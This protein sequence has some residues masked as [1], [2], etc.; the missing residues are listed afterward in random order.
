VAAGCPFGPA[1][2]V[3]PAVL[4]FG[5]KSERG[6][7][8][9]FNEGV[10]ALQ[11]TAAEVVWRG[12]AL[13]WVEE[14][15]PWLSIDSADLSGTTTV[16][17]ARVF[18]N[19]TRQGLDPG[20][21]AGAGIR[22]TSNG[23][24]MTVPVTM[25]VP[26]STGPGPDQGQL[27]VAPTAV[28]IHGLS[29][30]TTFM[31]TNTGGAIVQWYTAIRINAPDAQPD[32]PIQIAATPANAATAPVTTT[33][34]TVHVPNPAT[35]NS[36]FLT[37]V[38]AVKN[39][40]DDTVAAEVN[41]TVDLVGP[42]AI[43]A[44]PA[45]LD[46]GKDGY[47]VSFFVANVGDRYSLLNF[48]AFALVDDAY[49]PYDVEADPLIASI[50]AP[51]GTLGVK[52]EVET[53]WVNAREVSVTLSRDGI[54][55]DLEFRELYIGAVK[56]TDPSGKPMIDP[57]IAP[58]QVEVRVEAAPFVEGATN[59]SR[60]PSIMRFI[61]LLRDKRGLAVDAGDARIR[62]QMQFHVQEDG[63]PLD[64]DESS[65]F[66]TGP[67][68]LKCNVA[69]LLD[70][71]G[72]MYN[73]GVNDRLNP[74]E[75]GDAIVQMVESAKQFILDLPDS[76]RIA[77]ME[78]HDR[79]QPSR[80]IHGFDTDKAA[81]TGALDAFSLPV[82]EHGASDI[83]DALHDACQALVNEDPA[84]TLPF[85]EADV[86]SVVFVSDG[87][88][89]SSNKRI[90]EIIQFAK[91]SRVRLYPLGF[92]GR[93]STPVNGTVLIQLATE[94]GG[95]SYYAPELGDLT[96]LLDTEKE[97]TFNKPS[98]DL[99][100]RTAT[101]PLRNNGS[102]S[103]TWRALG[104]LNWLTV[105]PPSGT[106]PP[107]HRNTDGVID[108]PGV[109]A[110]TLTVSSGLT[111]GEYAGSFSI[112]SD[113]GNATVGVTATISPGGDLAVC[114]VTPRTDDAGNVWRELRGQV[115]LTYTSLFQSGNH[116][117]LIQATFPDAEGKPASAAFQKD[118]VF[119]GGDG[120][121][122]QISLTTTGIHDGK[123][124]VFVRADYVPRDI[125]QFRVRFIPDVPESLTPNLTPA[126][127]TALLA[128]LKAALD[129]DVVTLAPGGLLD[130]WRLIAEGFGIYSVVT[131][132]NNFLTYGAFGNLLKVTFDGLGANDA[133]TLGF[134]VDNSLYYSPAT[135]TSPSLTKYFLYPEGR[136]NPEGR[137]T[138][139][140]GTS[141]LAAPALTVADFGAPFDPEAPGT[142]DRD[143]DSWPDF[144][145][146]NPDDP[147]IGDRDHDGVPD[148]NDPALDDPT[149][150]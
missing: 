146:A 7:F 53:P 8:T 83:Y 100:A 115:V 94:T 127:R 104:N 11:W 141:N 34:V 67:E 74:L 77:L 84:Q 132:P 76:Y 18:L 2:V 64:P 147:N 89:T 145:D 120:R 15:V 98:V 30:S 17:T 99:S 13:G 12:Q 70:L 143:G 123:A 149:I 14:D 113:S 69:L 41:V 142:W 37:Y 96:R 33:T 139:A 90:N 27:Q 124:E 32:T 72:S 148:L 81:L 95:H 88:D 40:A 121:A 39:K 125:T 26:T 85:D 134:R 47:Q 92:S 52:A 118:A 23:G 103:V 44:D 122:G 126:Q 117:Y 48:A 28:T 107:L 109:R 129:G 97:L 60:P 4:D 9:I 31:V 150:P 102:A 58:K 42:P 79:G 55:K 119:Y 29:G 43:D 46:F 133:F 71:T 86:R 144:D 116:N 110:V 1:L 6:S 93:L 106:I 114:S 82:A 54:Q 128:S 16:E 35:F 59:R 137:L 136:L 91:D 22:V 131:E 73:A 10:G 5:D 75:P 45:V 78:Y 36:Q 140:P 51:E 105:S 50:Y 3:S 24:S 49:V 62:S 138:V 135:A 56:A 19:V 65:Q 20:T 38:V 108:E 111:P 87:W 57:D 63:L 80:V 130:G 25:R 66:V 61:F 68:S 21:Y 101:L 112:L